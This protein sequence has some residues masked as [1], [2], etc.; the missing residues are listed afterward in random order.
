MAGGLAVTLWGSGSPPALQE[1]RPAAQ[2]E[3]MK[4][5]EFQPD[6]R[7]M[8]V[9]HHLLVSGFM[10]KFYAG[11]ARENSYDR[12]VILSPNHFGL[13]HNLIQ[14]TLELPL[15]DQEAVNW[16]SREKALYL[17]GGDLALEH[18]LYVQYP[19][20]AEYFPG[21]KIV[22]IMIKKDT[23]CELLEQLAEQLIRL[24]EAQK[25]RTLILASLDFTHY[26]GEEIALANDLASTRWLA[27]KF[28]PT[29][30]ACDA[31][32]TLARGYDQKNSEAVAIDSGEALYVTKI[33]MQKMNAGTF[34]LW[35]RTSAASLL[36]GNLPAG[37][38]TSHLF[39]YFSAG[40]TGATDS[41]AAEEGGTG[42]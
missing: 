27:E 15:I 42:S 31:A 12:V 28:D 2:L 8:I 13:G 22:P 21:A 16:L 10:E 7:A 14:S 20:I 37:E 1:A 24:E 11:V 41:G 9:P 29:T 6:T 25:G 26:S 17:E 39:G 40:S 30:H 23:P 32:K 35:Q 34:R 4:V 33:L 19:F 38:N 36:S 3:R 5:A 18:G